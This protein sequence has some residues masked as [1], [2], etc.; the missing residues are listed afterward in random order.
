[1]G[2][3]LPAKP[4]SDQLENTSN[5]PGATVTEALD[6]LQTTIG[7]A[8]WQESVKTR[9]DPTGGLPSPTAGDRYLSTATANG[10]TENNIYQGNGTGFDE[11]VANEGMATWVEDENVS[12]VY[13]GS[14]WVK[15]AGAINHNDLQNIQGG[16]ATQRQHLSTAQHTGLTGGSDTSLHKHDTMYYTE[17]EI[18]TQMSGKENAFV[19]NSAFNKDFG[20]I[21]GTVCQGN[22]GRLSDARTPTLHASSHSQG[23]TDAISHNDLASIQGGS[24]SQRYHLSSADHSALTGGGATGLHTHIVH[25]SGITMT[26][27]ATVQGLLIDAEATEH[28]GLHSVSHLKYKCKTSFTVGAA[29]RIDFVSPLLPDNKY[30]NMR[31]DTITLADGDQNTS[32]VF[33][34]FV[35]MNPAY[36]LGNANHSSASVQGMG[37]SI[38]HDGTGMVRP[39]RFVAEGHGGN[40]EINAIYGKALGK[41]APG[42]TIYAGR[43]EVADEIGYTK[44]YGLQIAEVAAAGSPTQIDAGLHI[45]S[46]GAGMYANIHIQPNRGSAKDEYCLWLDDTQRTNG[47]GIVHTIHG[48]GDITGPITMFYQNNNKDH[49]GS[50]PTTFRG[51]YQEWSGDLP[52]TDD[53]SD[54]SLFSGLHTGD[55]GSGGAEGGEINIYKGVASGDIDGSSIIYSGLRLDLSGMGLTSYDK[56]YGSYIK[57]PADYSSPGTHAA[58]VYIEGEG[59]VVGLVMEDASAEHGVYVDMGGSVVFDVQTDKTYIQNYAVLNKTKTDTGD[60]AGEEGMVYINTFDNAIKMYAEGVWRT[61]VSW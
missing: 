23:Q 58:G 51:Y 46:S 50:I 54:L 53:D 9:Y 33:G 1:M 37:S 27:G 61:L 48:I 29:D 25:D 22:D 36:G 10:W 14:S 57:M 6:D 3:D 41:T 31:L 34:Y 52:Q 24:A 60:P 28:T 20:A 16:T 26:L 17:L 35:A 38:I 45:V 42:T 47:D 49:D 15:Q 12:Y 7:S 18:D 4:S 56:L 55:V 11:M 5:V 39:A 13:N 44:V 30:P 21:A 19:K 59:N 43:L 40:L 8:D 32:F 2:G